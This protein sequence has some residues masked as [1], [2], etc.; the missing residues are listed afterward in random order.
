[1]RSFVIGKENQLNVY[2]HVKTSVFQPANISCQ[3]DR[4]CFFVKI[5]YNLIIKVYYRFSQLNKEHRCCVL[6]FDKCNL[7]RGDLKVFTIRKVQGE[8]WRF[9]IPV[10]L[11]QFQ[12]GKIKSDEEAEKR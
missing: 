7:I 12:G 11:T 3:N 9:F 6:H 10:E 5:S 1:M 4:S 2:D 8:C